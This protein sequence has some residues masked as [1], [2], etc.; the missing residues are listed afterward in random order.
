MAG[1]GNPK[2]KK[3]C[4]SPNPGGRPKAPVRLRELYDHNGDDDRV[5]NRLWEWIHSDNPQA[6]M[7]AIKVLLERRYGG[8]ATTDDNGDAVKD[9]N[10]VIV[11]QSARDIAHTPEPTE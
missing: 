3:G 4:E 7:A 11:R 2:W 5:Y 9:T 6:S 8:V 1:P 10:I